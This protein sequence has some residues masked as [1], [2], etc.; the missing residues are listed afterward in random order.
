MHTAWE[1]SPIFLAPKTR[2]FLGPVS[3]FLCTLL[4]PLK[5]MIVYLLTRALNQFTHEPIRKLQVSV[6]AST[7][8][9]YLQIKA[10]SILGIILA[11]F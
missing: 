5:G 6:W 7:L 9:E 1:K 10:S 3:T 2:P 8:R 11:D 4:W